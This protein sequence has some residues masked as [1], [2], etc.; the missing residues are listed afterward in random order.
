[1]RG[2]REAGW[3]R[4]GAGIA[5]IAGDES[6]SLMTMMTIGAS[7]GLTYAAVEVSHEYHDF[8]VVSAFAFRVFVETAEGNASACGVVDEEVLAGSECGRSW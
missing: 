4:D 8:G 6:V 3:S 1:V 7:P 2:L 5:D